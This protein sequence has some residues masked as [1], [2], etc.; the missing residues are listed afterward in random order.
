M[1]YRNFGEFI[2]QAVV[3]SAP[4]WKRTA[5]GGY[6]IPEVAYYP[7]NWWELFKLKWFPL[8]LKRFLKVKHEKIP[9][10]ENLL[11]FVKEKSK[12]GMMDDRYWLNVETGQV[13]DQRYDSLHQLRTKTENWQNVL[14]KISERVYKEI[15]E[16]REKLLSIAQ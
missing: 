15:T 10:R 16:N 7:K 6:L 11:K 14:V 13:I 3:E 4:K 2:H 5:R 8:F 12:G 1:K 9:I